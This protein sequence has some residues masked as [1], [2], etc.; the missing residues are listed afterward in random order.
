[1][2]LPDPA[3]LT[4]TDA[5]LADGL[6]ARLIASGYGTDSIAAVERDVPTVLGAGR[7]PLIA[8]IIAD[9][10]VPGA[11]ATALFCY[12][13]VQPAGSVSQALGADAVEACLRHGVLVP[14]DGGLASPWRIVPFMDT[15]IASDLPDAGE[16]AVMGPGP[17]TSVL[18]HAGLP[19]AG[20]GVL[21]L[22]CGAG[23]LALAAMRAGAASAC[24]LDINPRAVAVA[25]ANAALNRLQLECRCGDLFAPVG[26]RRFDLIL[27]QPPYV[28]RPAG[29][30]NVT[31]LHS[32]PRGDE[33]ARRI[34]AEAPA[35][36][37]DGGL[38]MVH[39]DG[40]ADRDNALIGDIVRS[41]RARVD[42]AVLAHPGVPVATQA[43]SYATLLH[44]GFTDAYAIA[45][46]AYLDHCRAAGLASFV[47]YLVVL[48]RS[49]A[50]WGVRIRTSGQR[51]A[52]RRDLDRLLAGLDL[53]EAD[54]AH[55]LAACVRP[56]PGAE[57]RLHRP[58]G[59]PAV[60]RIEACYTD[61]PWPAHDIDE[62]TG[63]MCDIL[64][65]SADVAAAVAA[66]AEAGGQPGPDAT[67][68]VLGFVRDGLRR[69]VLAAG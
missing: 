52:R 32:G 69:G 1:M 43:M 3:S 18:A 59:E 8:G 35:F 42:I 62:D 51:P 19:A 26:G 21:D 27:S 66:Y 23:S 6:I 38:A 34:L 41:A 57:V 44:G 47:R 17:T 37:A 64:A 58:F 53:A 68:A 20:A 7:L 56:T 60:H 31:Y 54:D 25:R 45:V 10:G 48:R 30:A 36:L 12:A 67:R 55:L 4:A 46:R 61:A 63:A 28:I 11:V 39:F 9:G 22:G 16:D 33:L 40:P 49:S 65:G 29:G 24:A 13:L 2:N 14:R 5:D 15:M 50:G